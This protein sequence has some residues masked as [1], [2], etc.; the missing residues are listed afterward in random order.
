[1]FERG[2]RLLLRR[3]TSKQ[4]LVAFA[5]RRR[6]I[7]AVGYNSYSKTHP[8]QQYLSAK[9]GQQR[10]FLHA[11]IAALLKA[12]KDADSLY[13]MRINKQGELVNAA[14]CPICRLAIGLFN[15]KMKVFHS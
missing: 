15:P 3:S 2:R 1:M 5:V 10:P 9:V 12:P 6:R 11:E 7:V 14:P 13:V 4:N 8:Y